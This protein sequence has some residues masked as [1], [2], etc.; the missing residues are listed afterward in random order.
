VTDGVIHDAPPEYGAIFWS[1]LTSGTLPGLDPAYEDGGT[2]FIEPLD[3]L[4]LSASA[5]GT[6]AGKY[7]PIGID[8]VIYYTR[9]QDVF[10]DATWN[11][12]YN[13]SDPYA[14]AG[15]QITEKVVDY[16]HYG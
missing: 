10:A 9:I 3:W 15:T 4:M 6:T 16:D 5:M 11:L 14:S 1:L 8:A 12:E 2:A 13:E 7:V